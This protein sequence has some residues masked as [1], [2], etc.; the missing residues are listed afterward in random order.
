MI[1]LL[2]KSIE[3]YWVFYCFLYWIELVFMFLI[4]FDELKVKDFK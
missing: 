4:F 1:I 3:I 2:F